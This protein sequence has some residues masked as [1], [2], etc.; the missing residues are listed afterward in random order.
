MKRLVFFGIFALP[1]LCSAAYEPLN[2]IVA[3]VNDD[4]IVETQVTERET[5]VIDQLRDKDTPLPPADQLRQQ[6]LD[7]LVLENL[8]LQMARLNGVNVDDD[9]LNN[10][11]RAMAQENGLTLSEFRDKLEQE[12]YSYNSFREQMR[13]ELSI[14]R[15]RQQMVENNIQV[16]DQE[17]DNLLSNMSTA[18]DRN[19]E[20]HLAHILISVPEAASPAQLQQS[21]AKATAILQRL[22]AG[23]DFAE[24]AVAESDGQQA[25]EGGDLGWRSVDKLPSLFSDIVDKIPK[26]E[27]SG[28]IRSPSGFHIVK[29]VDIR[30]DTT[31]MITQTKARHILIKPSV[32]VTEDEARTRMEQIRERIELGD[33]FAKLAQTHSDDTTSASNGGD[34]GWI[35]PGEMVPEFEETMN[36]LEP[37][38]VSAP[39]KSR[40]GWHLIQIQERRTHDN[41]SEYQRMQARESIRRRK[42]DEETDI[43]LRR[44]R[45]ESYIEYVSSPP[46]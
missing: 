5:L 27:V 7:R 32:L 40:F 4:V 24:T 3:V 17:V 42:V 25:L 12:G 21:E 20:Y 6:V 29:V 15:L 22:R 45:D 35:N 1:V 10:S 8:Q 30:G 14:S 16:T 46:S 26:G 37:G 34:L 19:R 43:W 18:P 13:N 31:H 44:L 11:L 36:K 33:D 39:V 28:V 38:E 23:A 9:M 2:R 41:S